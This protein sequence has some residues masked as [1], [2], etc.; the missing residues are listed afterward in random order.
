M[1]GPIANRLRNQGNELSS[2]LFALRTCTILWGIGQQLPALHEMDVR[3]FRRN[4]QSLAFMP[5]NSG[6]LSNS[7][8]KT[9][10]KSIKKTG[11]FPNLLAMGRG[12]SA[13]QF[14]PLTMIAA[15]RHQGQV[16]TCPCNP[17]EFLTIFASGVHKI[18]R[19]CIHHQTA[20]AFSGFK[21]KL[22]VALSLAGPF[23][24]LL[25]PFSSMK[26]LIQ[27]EYIAKALKQDQA[28]RLLPQ[29]SANLSQSFCLIPG[30]RCWRER[31]KH[32]NQPE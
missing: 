24:P 16:A 20:F 23:S 2:K 30:S 8:A 26:E 4:S 1:S 17:G 31:S 10:K 14:G 9:E 3:A 6:T 15:L 11:F 12:L 18:V 25:V 28:Q 13:G 27:N 22:Y 7:F 29:Y 21:R 19:T 32:E 5:R